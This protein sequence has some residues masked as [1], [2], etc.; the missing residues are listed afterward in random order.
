MAGSVLTDFLADI[1]ESLQPG[2]TLTDTDRD[3]LYTFLYEQA[4]QQAIHLVSSGTMPEGMSAFAQYVPDCL[5]KRVV[6]R[7]AEKVKKAEAGK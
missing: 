7:L 1:A 3:K 2:L 4:T 6:A 5:R